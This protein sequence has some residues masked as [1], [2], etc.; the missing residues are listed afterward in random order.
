ML[1]NNH[2]RIL[3]ITFDG[4]N[5]RIFNQLRAK[6]CLPNLER[7]LFENNLF[8]VERAVSCFPSATFAN[9]Q[10]MH[11]GRFPKEPGPVYLNR[12]TGYVLNFLGREN[13][14]RGYGEYYRK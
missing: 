6:G 10:A 9:M 7:F 3:N 4:I 1:D 2:E 13:F 12:R 8:D 11:T 14:S 5:T